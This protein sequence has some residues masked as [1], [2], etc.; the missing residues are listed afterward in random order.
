MG[1]YLELKKTDSQGLQFKEQNPPPVFWTLYGLAGFALSCM[2]L[3]AHSLLF[4]LVSNGDPWDLLLVGSIMTAV[5]IY[6]GIGFKLLWVRKYILF[7]HDQV[8]IGYTIGSGSFTIRTLKRSDVVDV[9]LINQKP[10]SNVAPTHHEDPQYY[11]RGHWRL[12]L[13]TKNGKLVPLDRHTEKGALES[14]LNS[15][16]SWL[17]QQ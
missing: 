10:S 14:L 16:T 3:A 7:S 6:L 12:I 8:Q 15:S 2:G 17:Q 4:Q 9:Y 13:K 1:F 5:P 11:I